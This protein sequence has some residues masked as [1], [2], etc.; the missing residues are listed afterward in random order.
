MTG[1]EPSAYAALISLLDAHRSQYRILDHEPHG[2]TEIVS[3]LRGHPPSQAAKCMV[4]MVK[5]GKRVTRYVLAVVP[6]DMQVDLGAIKD[7]LQGTYVAFASRGVAENLA[8]AAPGAIL[9]FPLSNRLELIVD[10]ELLAHDELFFNAGRLDRSVAL[11][12]ADYLAITQPRLERIARKP[13]KTT[14]GREMVKKVRVADKFAAFDDHWSPKII[15]ELNDFY[16]K[17]VKLKGEFIWHHHDDE[18]E[19]FYVVTGKLVIKLRDGDVVLEPGEFVVIPH[20][21]EHLPVADEEAHVLLL[22][23]KSTVN[24]GTISNERTVANLERV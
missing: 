20:L 19:L 2:Q 17:A 4:V 14:E 13:T 1:V 8:G 15:G 9:P 21:V 3:L 6:G 24:T 22:E 18:D 16:V 7:L 11:R 5:R 10:P 12:T 23:R